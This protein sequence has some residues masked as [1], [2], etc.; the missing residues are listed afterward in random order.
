MTCHREHIDNQNE[1]EVRDS[2]DDTRQQPGNPSLFLRQSSLSVNNK[3][4]SYQATVEFDSNQ[5][6]GDS[7][8]SKTAEVIVEYDP[9]SVILEESNAFDSELEGLYLD[10]PLADDN[11]IA[12]YGSEV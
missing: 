11:W 7:D 12:E 3:M 8:L 6:S 2:R 4:S 5:E 1:R 9:E 10:E